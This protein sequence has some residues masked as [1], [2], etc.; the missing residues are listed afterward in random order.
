MKVSEFIEWLKTQDQDAIVQV[1]VEDRDW[2]WDGEDEYS[3][4]TVRTEVFDPDYE[5]RYSYGQKTK[6]LTLG[7]KW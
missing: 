1:V 6:I 2:G 7:E 5:G 3:Y 4:S